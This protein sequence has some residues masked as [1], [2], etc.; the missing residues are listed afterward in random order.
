LPTVGLLP[1]A[2]REAYGLRWRATHEAL[3][4]V[5]SAACRRWWSL[6]PP[7]LRYWP[8]AQVTV[9]PGP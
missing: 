8:M 6:T 7:R 9:M 2:V 4:G 3:L 1:P 5:T